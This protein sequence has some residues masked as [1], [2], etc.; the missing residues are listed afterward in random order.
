MIARLVQHG[1]DPHCMVCI[2]RHYASDEACRLI[3]LDRLIEAIV[4]ADQLT[5]LRDLRELCTNPATFH[6]LGRNQR[7]RAVRSLQTSK[8]FYERFAKDADASGRSDFAFPWAALH[9]LA[10]GVLMNM[11][12]VKYG[13]CDTCQ[14]HN[15]ALFTAIWCLD[16]GGR[17][18]LCYCCLKRN[19]CKLPTLACSYGYCTGDVSTA[20][21]HTSVTWAYGERVSMIQDSDQ[22]LKEDV[23]SIYLRYPASQAIAIMEEWY[24]RDPIEL[25]NSFEDVVRSSRAASS[26]P[27]I[28]TPASGRVTGEVSKERGGISNRAWSSLK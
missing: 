13:F 5:M 15:S 12:N 23:K 28:Q 26:P 10:L 21:G 7:R 20:T 4:P 22:A 24:A 2:T 6:T 18:I 19:H 16:C 17:S 25:D 9:D 14:S 3:V 27:P 8:Q 1:A 11:A